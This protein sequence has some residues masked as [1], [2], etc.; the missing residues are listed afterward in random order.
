MAAAIGILMIEVSSTASDGLQQQL[1]AALQLSS[2][3]LPIGAFSYS[4]G[5]ESAVAAGIVVDE[6]SLGTWVAEGLQF[7][8]GLLELAVWCL[9]HKHWSCG[10]SL[11]LNP[12]DQEKAFEL[13][14]WFLAS[15]ETAELCLETEQMGWSAQALLRDWA[16]GNDKWQ[17][18]LAR[19]PVSLPT[20]MSALAVFEGIT[21]EVGA[22]AYAFAWLEGQ[23]IAGSKSIPLGQAAIQRLLRSQ[24]ANCTA[25]VGRAVQMKRDDLETF[26]PGLALL[27]SQHETLYTRLYRS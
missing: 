12:S 23:V 16:Q 21:I 22:T 2:P 25:A 17:A 1:L 10:S 5:L 7:S 15:R 18:L 13:D 19:R 4:Q 26:S 11:V 24:R 20:I 14:E 6:A 8:F 27:S 9:Q 3:A